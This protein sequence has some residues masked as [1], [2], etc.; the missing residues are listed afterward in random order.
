MQ[1]FT[2][3][4]GVAAPLIH[5]NID[6]DAIIPSREI[7]RVSRRGLDQG[8]FADWRYHY[9]GKAKVG[10]NAD[11]VLNRPEYQQ[12]SIL[13]SGKNF[14]CGSSREYAV[15]ALQEYGI[16]VIIAVSFGTIFYNNCMRNG[17]LPI[18]LHADQ[19]ASLAEYVQAD[20]GRRLEIDLAEQTVSC[21]DGS[22]YRFEIEKQNR[23][24]LLNGLDAIDISK[25]YETDI[26][27]F[28]QR[29]KV[30]RPWIYQA[31]Q[32]SQV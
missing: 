13:L 4:S 6:T 22:C 8:L 16:R 15:W 17:V 32:R 18:C 25:T 21:A 1:K 5:S 7:K 23:N 9:E 26:M 12:A 29:D 27:Q 28:I 31:G 10:I 11:F 19:I 20:P 30:K 2:R 14:G 3:H 24:M